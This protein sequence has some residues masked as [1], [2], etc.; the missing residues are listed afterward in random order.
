V[1]LPPS[2]LELPLN[3]EDPRIREGKRIYEECMRRIKAKV[4]ASGAELLAV[5]L[6]SKHL[7]YRRRIA[8]ADS[9]GTSRML[10][11][12]DREA[13]LITA[14]ESFFGDQGIASINTTEALEAALDND[15]RPFPESDDEHP[16]GEGYAAIAEAVLPAYRKLGEVRAIDS[17]L[18]GGRRD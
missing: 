1:F 11:V 2:V 7:V 5:I 4:E 9:P 15:R 16:N 6:P 10:E 3:L 13:R 14:I 18:N 12:I 17:S 8:Q